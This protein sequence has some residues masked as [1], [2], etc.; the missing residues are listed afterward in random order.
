MALTGIKDVDFL[1]L[2]LLNDDELGKVCQINKTAHFYCNDENF[3]LNRTQSKFGKF[4]LPLGIDVRDYNNGYWKDY[5]RMMKKIVEKTTKRWKIFL[6]SRFVFTS[7]KRFEED[8]GEKF[9]W[10]LLKDKK[11][12]LEIGDDFEVFKL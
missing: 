9:T 10:N 6:Q 7:I 11:F 2:D 4:L 5:Y 8:Y 12:G 1:I 3:W